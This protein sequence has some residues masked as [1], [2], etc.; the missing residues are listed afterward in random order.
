[1]DTNKKGNEMKDLLQEK[2]YD[3]DREMFRLKMQKDSVT[4]PARDRMEGRIKGIS[5]C[6]HEVQKLR[7][8]L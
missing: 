3:L 6:I 1:M 7:L 5:Y 8:S 2:I 4:G